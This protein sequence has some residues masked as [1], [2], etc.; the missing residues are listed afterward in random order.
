MLGPKITCAKCHRKF[1]VPKAVE[2]HI[3]VAFCPGCMSEKFTP[4]YL[5]RMNR[6]FFLTIC[7]HMDIA[8]VAPLALDICHGREI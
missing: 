1:R 5:Y 3:E 2:K 6:S 4:K 8:P 7:D